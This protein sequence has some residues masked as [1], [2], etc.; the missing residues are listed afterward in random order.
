MYAA[1]PKKIFGAA[2]ALP[3]G[4]AVVEVRRFALRS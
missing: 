1:A 4:D 3:C 2:A